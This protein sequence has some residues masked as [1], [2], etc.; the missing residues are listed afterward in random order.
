MRASWSSSPGPVQQGRQAGVR[1][2]QMNRTTC[3]RSSKQI[4]GEMSLFFLH[5]GRKGLGGRVAVRAQ[6]WTGG[7]TIMEQARNHAPATFA[8]Q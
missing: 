4:T 8:G 2:L 7:A 6:I 3:A 1:V 5:I